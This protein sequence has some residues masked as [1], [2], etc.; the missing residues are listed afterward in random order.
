LPVFHVRSRRSS[1]LAAPVVCLTLLI[2]ACGADPD[3]LAAD[4][5][6]RAPLSHRAPQL[7]PQASGV[8]VRL[9]SVSAVNDRVAWASGRSGTVLRTI[10][11]GETWQVRPVPGAETL[12]FRDVQAIDADVAYVLTNNG[13]TNARIY[14]T[15][16]GGASWTL[17][18]QGP[19]VLLFYDCFAFWSERRGVAVPD[20]ENGR[21]E[22]LRTTDGNSWTDIGDRFPAAQSGE[23]FFPASG[24]CVATFGSKRAWAVGA[25]ATTARV[26]V[27][28]DG[29][30]SWSWYPI[31]LGGTAT[32]GGTTIAFRD[33]RHGVLGGGDVT[34]GTPQPNFARSHD[35]GRT[36]ALGPPA[37]F[38]GPMFG[39][40][41]AMRPPLQRDDDDQGEDE[42]EGNGHHTL[43]AT[44]LLGSAW[45]PDEGD[46][47]QALDP[48]TVAGYAGVSFGSSR[49][50]WLVGLSGKILR[51]DF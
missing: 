9:D 11:G 8:T 49:R 28:D 21:F 43:V 13:G 37:P 12:A 45:S 41:Y 26:F 51:V 1:S 4:A 32:S 15:V 33:A 35:G 7:T 30:D 31:P 44:G 3:G 42:E 6:A 27:T 14:K 29:G 5:R 22:V 47:W 24:T 50:G 40:A 2:V 36:W 20:A 46:T 19:P 39:L 48:A 10:D 38:P 25:G 18:F 23:G 17:Q 16:D 34:V